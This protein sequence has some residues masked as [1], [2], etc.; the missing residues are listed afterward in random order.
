MN[1]VDAMNGIGI[2]PCRNHEDLAGKAAPSDL[3]S[4]IESIDVRQ[5]EIEDDKIR[6]FPRQTLNGHGPRL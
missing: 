2:T 1:F 3:F 5:H 4:D 6:P